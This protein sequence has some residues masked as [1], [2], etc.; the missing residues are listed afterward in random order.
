MKYLF[1]A[2]AL[3]LALFL[4]GSLSVLG[5]S[6]DLTALLAFYVGMREGETKGLLAGVMIGALEDSLASSMIGPNLLAKAIVGFSSSFFVSGGL[7]RWT[8]LLGVI[9]VS[10]L[11]AVDGFTVFLTRTLFDRAP[12]AASMAL[13]VSTMQSILNAPA[14]IFVRPKNAD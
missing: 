12:T 8:P 7:L 14:G 1:F 10:L 2:A 3:F 9:V 11:T 6:P 5:I 13:F 4:Q